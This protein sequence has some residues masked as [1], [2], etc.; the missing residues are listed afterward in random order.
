MRFA[1]GVL[2]RME[3]MAL[4]QSDVVKMSGVPQSTISAVLSKQRTPTEDTMVM[5][6]K[7]LNCT[8]GQLLGEYKKG[9]D[10]YSDGLTLDEIDMDVINLFHQLPEDQKRKMVDFLSGFVER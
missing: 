5:I 6:A 10:A 8:V 4:K 9:P 1:D 2:Q 7:G 3:E